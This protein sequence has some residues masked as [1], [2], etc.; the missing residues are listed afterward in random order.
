MSE[1][2]ETV[3][4]KTTV[5][6]YIESRAQ[7]ILDNKA[8]A[9]AKDIV[10]D[11]KSKSVTTEERQLASDFYQA[12]STKNMRAI[13]EV[14]ERVEKQWHGK[15]QEIG[16][17]GT[18][19]AGGVLVPTTVA[20]S[21]I[22]QLIYISPMRQI[23]QVIDNMP[24]Q[25]QLPNESN[26]VT[27]YW[28]AEATGITPSAEVFA[29][30]ILTPYKLAG[31]DTFTS[32][33]L[34]DAATNPSI[35]RFVENRFAVALALAENAAFV[36]GTGSG[37]PWGFRSSQVTPASVAQSGAGLAYTDV[38]ALMFKLAT[39]YRAQGVFLTSS[40]GLQALVN[41]RDT[42]GRPIW[43]DSFSGLAQGTTGNGLAAGNQAGTVLGRPLYVI[44]EIPSNL[45]SGSN[46]TE[47]WY[48]DPSRY[49]IGDRQGLTVDYGTQ[50][51][52]FAADQISLRV[53]KRVAGMP[54]DS[55]AFAKLTGVISS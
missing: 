5:K 22:E 7:E 49:V 8:K 25:L 30:N 35:Q 33:L 45:G 43:I 39:A 44:D 50:G 34:Q 24:A 29:P 26:L 12:L 15:V 23:A 3:D 53:V 38:T 55:N 20:D 37:Q 28:V 1:T 42:Q 54:I 31:L 51:T 36:S 32:E 4:K 6:Q 13:E 10:V 16:T 21:I 11:H 41:V 9:M 2:Q 47:L 40:A 48:I 27:A 19:T 17:I 52:D 46:H 18:G 14:N